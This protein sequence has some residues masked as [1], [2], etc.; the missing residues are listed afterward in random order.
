M[1]NISVYAE[2][3]PDSK[4]QPAVAASDDKS[5]AEDVTNEDE[6]K[7]QPAV[8]ESDDKSLAKDATNEDEEKEQPAVAASD[9][10]SL[11]KDVT[12]EDENIDI[13]MEVTFVKDSIQPLNRAMFT[14]NDK[15]YYWFFRPLSK[16][17]EAV[18]PEKARLGVRNF[19]TNVRTPGRFVN[20]ILQGKFK[21]AGSE[22]LRLV[23]NSTLGVGGFSDPATKYFKLD[24]YDEDFGQTLGT[25]NVGAGTFIEIP[26]F[27]PSN[28]RDGIG[29]LGDIILDPITFLSFVSP[30][31]STGVSSYNTLNE[32]SIDKGDTYEGLVEQA[33]DPYI[34]VQDAYTQNRAKKIR[35]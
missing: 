26:L 7:E 13:E 17:Y 2:D 24:M 18:V 16:G 30:F 23:I 15:V 11:A 33:I 35:E 29:L 8:A 1:F 4:E 10:K 27:G 9:D 34:A 5:L 3:V 19:F 6:E 22:L 20:C 21:G 14:F 12:N 32:V 28:V 25:Y 31:L